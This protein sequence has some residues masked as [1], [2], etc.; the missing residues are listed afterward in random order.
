MVASVVQQTKRALVVLLRALAAVYGVQVTVNRDSPDKEVVVA[1]RRVALKAHP[2]HGGDAS[3]RAAWEEASRKPERESTAPETNRI[4]MSID[5]GMFY[6]WAN[7][8]GTHRDVSGGLCVAGNYSPGW[9]GEGFH[10]QVLGA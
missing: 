9:C 5:R 6:V 8:V 2:D 3:E 10:Y 1:C 7:K 4:Q